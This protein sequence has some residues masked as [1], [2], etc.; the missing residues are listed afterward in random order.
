[1]NFIKVS[2][3]KDPRVEMFTEL[4]ETQLL[5]YYEPNGGVFVAESPMVI[6]RALDK[7]YEP[8]S[9]FLEEKFI[10]GTEGKEFVDSISHFDVPVYVAPRVT[11]NEITGYN[12]TR[13]ELCA[14]MRREHEPSET[15]LKRYKKVAVLED[16]M[17]LWN[18]K[19]NKAENNEQI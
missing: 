16:V 2:D 14:F 10:D 7:G 8:L 6:E 18:K 11:M 15:F 5:H 9:F 4:N 17:T 19:W 1:M 3:T 13:G 12:I